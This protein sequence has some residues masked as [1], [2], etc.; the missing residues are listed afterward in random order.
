MKLSDRDIRL[1]SFALY[2]AF[3][4]ELGLHLAGVVTLPPFLVLVSA[5]AL[6]FLPLDFAAKKVSPRYREWVDSRKETA[7]ARKAAGEPS[8]TKRQHVAISVGVAAASIS[9]AMIRVASRTSDSI[10]SE[11]IVIP[12]VSIALGFLAALLAYNATT[13]D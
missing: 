9:L 4:A 5:L 13:A 10:S 11:P 3:A 6:A 7:R 1:L 8:V 12:V 2:L